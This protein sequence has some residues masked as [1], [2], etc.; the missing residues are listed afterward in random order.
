MQEYLTTRNS[1]YAQMQTSCSFVPQLP[2]YDA[3]PKSVEEYTKLISS[4]I[5]DKKM[6]L[7]FSKFV[8]LNEQFLLL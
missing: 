4:Q 3:A 6:Q 7:D 2:H 8:H 1:E 5:S